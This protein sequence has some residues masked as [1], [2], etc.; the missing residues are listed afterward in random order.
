M[1]H[2]RPRCAFIGMS[3]VDRSAIETRLPRRP[4]LNKPSAGFARNPSSIWEINSDSP[5]RHG[6]HGAIYFRS[7]LSVSCMFRGEF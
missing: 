4:S 2:R 7:V 1:D 6:E 5:R 3:V